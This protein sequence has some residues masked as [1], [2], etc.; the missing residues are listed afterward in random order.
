MATCCRILVPFCLLATITST[1]RVYPHQLAYFNEIAGGP[2]NGW[3]HLLHSNLDWG[4]DSLFLN[5][6][7]QTHK[8][9][10]C[11]FKGKRISSAS[12]RA[13]LPYLSISAHHENCEIVYSPNAIRFN[14]INENRA[15]ESK[16]FFKL[17]PTIWVK[18]HE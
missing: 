15:I 3:K 14:H 6:Y 12:L 2:E 1:L 16:L 10:M 4:R 17:T 7:M 9:F 13:M 5:N 11:E 8:R 18:L